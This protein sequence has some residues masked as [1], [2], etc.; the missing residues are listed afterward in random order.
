[1]HVVTGTSLGQTHPPAP[2][3]LIVNSAWVVIVGLMCCSCQSYET[4]EN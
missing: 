2:D 3:D 1:M 4:G